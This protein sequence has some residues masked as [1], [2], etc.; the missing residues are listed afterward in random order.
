MCRYLTLGGLTVNKLMLHFRLY[1]IKGKQ[2]TKRENGGRKKTQITADTSRRFNRKRAVVLVPLHT[3]DQRLNTT[4]R[5]A[6]R[7]NVKHKQS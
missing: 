2:R 3:G 5:K 6:N 4:V 7:S 1:S